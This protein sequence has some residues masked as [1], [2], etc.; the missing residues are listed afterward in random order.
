QLPHPVRK[1]RCGTYGNHS[2]TKVQGSKLWMATGGHEAESGAFTHGQGRAS[3]PALNVGIEAGS[4][5]ED[6]DDLERARIDHDDLVADQDELIAA[7][8]RIDRHDFRR[9]RME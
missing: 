7:P 4:G 2:L 3:L 9:Q 1:K 6:R 8:I 5:V